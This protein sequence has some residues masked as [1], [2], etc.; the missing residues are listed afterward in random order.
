ML[1]I[2]GI[3]GAVGN[4][5]AG[6]TV[7]RNLRTTFVVACAG[8][9]VSLLLLLAAGAR[10]DRRDRRADPLGRFVRCLAA[11]S[12]Q[13]HT[14]CRAQTPSRPRP[15]TF[16]A[17]MSLNTMAYNTSI[18]IGALIGGPFVDNL[19]VT[20][21]AWFGVT[22]TAASLVLMVSTARRSRRA[23]TR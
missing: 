9:V 21:V 14:R 4:F 1:M 15:N 20:S 2:F 22:L 5:I 23:A 13:P 16:E 7:T 17:A 6:H 19:G 18:A 8:L 10:A 12:A 3:S 11:V